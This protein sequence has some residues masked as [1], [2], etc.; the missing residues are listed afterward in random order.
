MNSEYLLEQPNST[1]NTSKNGVAFMSN[2]SSQKNNNG[3]PA[4]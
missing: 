4:L 1:T 2:R 3:T